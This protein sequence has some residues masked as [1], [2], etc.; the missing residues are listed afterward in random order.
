MRWWERKWLEGVSM[1]RDEREKD[2]VDDECSGGTVKSTI[3]RRLFP[4]PLTSGR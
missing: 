2:A 4:Q 1:G 3:P